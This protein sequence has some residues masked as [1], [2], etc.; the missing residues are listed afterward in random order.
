MEPSIIPI[1]IYGP[2]AR[3]DIPALCDRLRELLDG[4]GSGR[5]ICDVGE[6]AP[7]DAAAVD[8]LA[9]LQLTARRFGLEVR[10]SRPSPELVE[11]L[12]LMGLREIL[13]PCD[14]LGVETRGQS[15]EREEGL[16][17]KKERDPGDAIL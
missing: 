16:G 6:L 11:L 13:P 1:A 3:A 2:I 12:T 10:L 14:P 8:G 7:P 17:V 5:V 9:R 4:A 15:K